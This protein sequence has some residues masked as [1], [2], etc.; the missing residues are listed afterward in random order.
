MFSTIKNYLLAG[1]AVL[2]GLLAAAAA[3][4]KASLESA[5]LKGE[6][7]ARKVES[8]AADAMIKGLEAENEIKDNNS[9]D[10][11]KFLD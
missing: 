4:Y 3:W 7:R 8:K 11:D 10:R 9:T 2:V 5:Q 6:K 1:L